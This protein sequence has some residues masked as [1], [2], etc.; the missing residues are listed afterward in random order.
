MFE[1][2]SVRRGITNTP[3]N[4]AGE[5]LGIEV[6]FTV[7]SMSKILHMPISG[8][9]SMNPLKGVFDE[10]T[11]YTD[12]MAILSGLGME[13]HVY[14]YRRIMLN[15]TRKTVAWDSY[16]NKAR[17]GLFVRNLPVVNM[18]DVFYSGRR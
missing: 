12:Y 3:Y 13:D 7:A 14:N 8:N 6:S 16:W 10:E 11:L 5:T 18:L 4:L 15:L 17:F 1:S 2:V 9:F